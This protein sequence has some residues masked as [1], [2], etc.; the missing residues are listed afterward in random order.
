MTTLPVLARRAG[1]G[2]LDADHLVRLTTSWGMLAD[3]CFSDLLLYVPVT[4]ELRAAE[5][6]ESEPKYMI[7][8][9]VRPATSR[10]LYSRDLVGTVVPASSTPGITQCMTTGHIAF[11]ESRMMH[12]D[13]HR[14]SFCIP[15]RHHDK[16]VAVMVR[17]YELNS[18]RVRGELE[19]EYVSLFERFAN[20]I[21]RGE[22]PFYVD[23][24][25]EAPRVGDGV[26]VL[27]Q[28]GNIT[29][30][31]PNAASG[32]HRLGHFSARVGDH[33]SELG[34]DMT[35]AERARVTRLPVVEEVETRP[36][37]I[38]IFHAIPLLADG[39]YSGALVLMRDITE[40]RRRDRL[41]LSKDATIRE[42][43]HR[44]KNNLQTIS[45]LLRLQA[46]RIGSDAG[47][48]SL[49]EAERRIRSMALVHEI[50]SRDVGDQVDFQEVVGAVVQLAQESV[51]PGLMLD[52]SVAGAPGE[53]D[54]AK[55]T[56][57][58]LTIAE[59]IQNS[60]EHA[61][62]GREEGRESRSGSI[63]ISL[64]RG[65]ECLYIEVADTGVGFPEGFD[66]EN[67][68]S[69]GLAIVRSL[70]TTQLGGSIRFES[71]GGARVLIEVPVE[72]GLE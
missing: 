48:G 21:T 72:P 41:L 69:L 46:R 16:V 18:K 8:A 35:A 6:T 68:S 51:P 2:A 57:L 54:A 50:L 27:D 58:A 47:R 31:S 3:L 24:P 22:F 59:L 9:Q 1:V 70:V 62:G 44:V 36:D 30:M 11:R 38:I 10:T 65:E 14:V 19:R 23:E 37:S 39:E 40:L 28:D 33:F 43:H 26:M 17:E 61:F 67:S 63:T 20:M 52:I 64:S 32:L 34:V 25:A 4:G 42:V 29:F 7:V 60:I 45:S 12:A 5:G 71:Q 66:P 53:L 56:P 55:A 13:E 49:M 15:V